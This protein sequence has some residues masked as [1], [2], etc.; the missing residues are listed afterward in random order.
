MRMI[1]ALVCSVTNTVDYKQ[2]IRAKCPTNPMLHTISLRVCQISIVHLHTLNSTRVDLTNFYFSLYF[3]IP[4]DESQSF[5]STSGKLY[6]FTFTLR[7]AL[8][9]CVVVL[10]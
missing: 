2:A 9:H 5:S 6:L 10:T 7:S 1:Y 3:F 8:F 4:L